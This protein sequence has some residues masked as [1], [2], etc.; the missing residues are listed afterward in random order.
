MATTSINEETIGLGGVSV[1]AQTYDQGL[2]ED[3]K[4]RK[5]WISIYTTTFTAEGDEDLGQ[6]MMFLPPDS[7]NIVAQK[8]GF[9]PLCRP[10]AVSYGDVLAEDFH[11]VPVDTDDTWAV[12][13]LVAF[14][15]IVDPEPNATISFRQE[16]E[17]G[18]AFEMASQ[19]GPSPFTIELPSGIY[20]VVVSAEGRETNWVPL[21]LDPDALPPGEERV[22]EVNF[23]LIGSQTE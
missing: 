9:I 6:Y 23:T 21:P 18:Q 2:S 11:L 22:A 7:Y 14:D 4:D 10:V 8:P 12:S 1:S 3:P 5:D 16:C 19:S 20:E 13:V 17:G 15:P